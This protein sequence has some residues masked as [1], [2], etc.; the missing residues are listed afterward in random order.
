MAEIIRLTEDWVSVPGPG[1]ATQAI[2]EALDVSKYDILDLFV[3][4]GIDAG[5]SPNL[6]I[7]LLSGMSLLSSS[8]WWEVDPANYFVT[9]MTDRVNTIGVFKPINAGFYRYIRWK[10]V[11]SASITKAR[12]FIEGMG[13]SYR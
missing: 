1:T 6:K 13:R 10:A 4:T 12:F 2:S 5:A 9:I 7:T 3:T 11:L 8:S